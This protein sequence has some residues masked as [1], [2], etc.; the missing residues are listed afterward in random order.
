MNFSNVTITV[1]LTLMIQESQAVYLPTVGLD[2]KF[3]LG[4]KVRLYDPVFYDISPRGELRL[5]RTLQN[6][7]LEGYLEATSG[8][9]WYFG[10]QFQVTD[11]KADFQTFQGLM[12]TMKLEA[13]HRLT[14]SLILLQGE[15]IATQMQF[16]LSSEPTMSQEEIRNLLLFKT[17]QVDINS[18]EFSQQVASMGAMALLEMSLQS[19]RLFGLEK[20]AQENFGVD[21]L[22]LAQVRFYNRSAED[23]GRFEANY[24][25]RV[26]K[27]LGERVYF[28]HI[29]SMDEPSNGISTL[30]YDFNRYWNLSGE[31]ERYERENRYQMFLRGR[32]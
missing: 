12:P 31:L 22:Q 29:L 23:A 28:S 7:A 14:N 4:E 21:E 6:P 17:D 5:R 27:S 13:Q 20:F 9:I 32:F 25:V 10:N 15:G 30:R 24:G 2:V 26:G 1:P 19:Q 16:N 8:R 3:N 11:A 18:P